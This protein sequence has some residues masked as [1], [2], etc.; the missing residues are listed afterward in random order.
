MPLSDFFE[1]WH[2][3]SRYQI[4]EVVVLVVWFQSYMGLIKVAIFDDFR[5][6]LNC[7]YTGSLATVALNGR[8]VG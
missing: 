3:C 1:T 6:I 8:V 5:F 7:Q 2:T 4:T